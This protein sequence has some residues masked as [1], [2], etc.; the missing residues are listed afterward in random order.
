[1]LYFVLYQVKC[2]LFQSVYLVNGQLIVSRKVGFCLSTG[3][4]QQ[5]FEQKTSRKIIVITWLF[6]AEIVFHAY[7]FAEKIIKDHHLDYQMVAVL[8]FH[9]LFSVDISV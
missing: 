2:L 3:F 7:K 1:M 4:F 9:L 8:I 6:R 5:K